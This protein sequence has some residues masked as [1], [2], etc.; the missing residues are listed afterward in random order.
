MLRG[1][2]IIMLERAQSGGHLHLDQ[3]VQKKKLSLFKFLSKPLYVGYYSQSITETV[4]TNLSPN[5]ATVINQ[6]MAVPDG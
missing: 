1:M 2:N 3:Y 6:I 5:Y 4:N